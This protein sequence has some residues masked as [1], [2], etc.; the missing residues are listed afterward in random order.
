MT[1]EQAKGIAGRVG[2]AVL[3]IMMGGGG[4]WTVVVKA[5][6]KQMLQ[7]AAN[8]TAQIAM[9]QKH[10]EDI[11]DVRIEAEKLKDKI[12]AIQMQQVKISTTQDANSETLR[13]MSGD[14][15]ILIRR[16]K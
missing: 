4:A 11:E 8:T 3:A 5:A 9:A 7:T 12:E 1:K 6:E 15:K 2:G 14:I 13:E 16:G 10:K